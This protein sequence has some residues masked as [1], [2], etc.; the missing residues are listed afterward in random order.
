MRTTTVGWPIASVGRSMLRGITALAVIV[1]VAP[2]MGWKVLPSVEMRAFHCFD[3]MFLA[4]M[5]ATNVA[6]VKP[7]VENWNWKAMSVVR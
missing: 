4:A 1:H 5:S 7:T 6:V 2:A 3:A